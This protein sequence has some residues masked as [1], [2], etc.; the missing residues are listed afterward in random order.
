MKRKSQATKLPD[1]TKPFLSDKTPSHEKITLLEK[2]KIIK[3]DSKTAN[4]LNTF[5]ST[6]I[7]NLNIPEY[8]VL[9]PISDDINDPVLKPI[10]KYKDH[11]RI[12]AIETISNLNSLFKFSNVEKREILNEIINLDAL[13]SCQD[14]DVPTKIIKENVDIFVDFIHRQLV[15]LSIKTSFHVF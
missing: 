7:N 9:D 10:R 11:P 13:K 1:K 8:P 12:K 6:I 4:A 3:T 14:T 5:F 2:D 15:R